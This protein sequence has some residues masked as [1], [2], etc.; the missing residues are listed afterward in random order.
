MANLSNINNVLRVSTNLRVG[1]NTDAASYAL[2][3]GGTNS[4][5]KLKNSGASGKVYSLL[6]DTSGNFQIYDDAATS[7][8]L[9]I[10]SGGDAT[11][12]GSVT[13]TGAMTVGD[14][15]IVAGN[16]TLVDKSSSEVGSILLGSGNDLQIYHN[17]SDSFVSDSGTGDL[18]LRSNSTAIIKSANTKIE[19]FGSTNTQANFGNTAVEL[20]SNNVKRL[21]TEDAGVTIIGA[22]NADSVTSTGSATFGANVI[23]GDTSG[24]SP[25]SADRFL[26]IGK[27][28]LQDCS[29]ILQDA[30]ET[31]EIYQNDDLSFSYGTTPTTVLTLARTTGTAT[32]AGNVGIGISPS[33]SFSG[34]D[35][36]QLGKGM[37]LMGNAND[38]R[39]AMMAN[40]YLDSNTAFRYVM[41]GLAGKVAIEDGIITFGTAP[42]GI[43]GEVAT[44]TERMRITSGGNVNIGSGGLTQAAYHLRVDSDFDNGIY[45]S[46]GTG[47]SDHALY[48]DNAA[49]DKVLLT[50]RG[51]GYFN[52]G[53]AAN[54][55]YNVS[56]VGRDAYISSAGYLGYLSSTRK[57]K[58]NIK[59]I[60][61]VDWLYNLNVVKFNYRKR[62]EELDYLEE[63]ENEQKYGLIA[64]EVE[65]V[66]KDFCWYSKDNNLEGVDYKMLIAP[67][68]KSIQELKAEIEILKNK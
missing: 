43:A 14:D 11:F 48:I 4:G 8:R 24:T 25:N 62:N 55:P 56:V 21:E 45:L 5:I 54:S 40:L 52:V 17:G 9:V 20:Y 12:A 27:S 53:N 64:E 15:V 58:T 26:K 1:I 10:S 16:I 63:A 2:E 33:A 22:L 66:N 37:T 35:V 3:I 57:S 18:I 31:W 41:D 60:D 50:I 49:G 46:A 28:D 68:I 19:A 47:S 34:V 42:S 61:N 7:G 6:S 23:V 36:L 67:L 65:K 30:V 32:F 38:D 59:S 51:D 44:V 13:T 29:I 39:A